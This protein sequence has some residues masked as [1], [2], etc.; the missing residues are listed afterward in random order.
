MLVFSRPVFDKG[1][2]L[3]GWINAEFVCRKSVVKTIEIW[4]TNVSVNVSIADC[5]A[6]YI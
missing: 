3:C 4:L 5:G 2:C 1:G 6:L